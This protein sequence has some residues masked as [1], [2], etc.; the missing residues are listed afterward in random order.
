[1]ESPQMHVRGIERK[2]WFGDIINKGFTT[3]EKC[4]VRMQGGGSTNY[5]P[6]KKA[7]RGRRALGRQSTRQ[8]QAVVYANGGRVK[9]RL[10]KAFC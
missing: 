2:K 5:I 10:W 1:M 3:A 4:L 9:W 7:E 8:E 6:E